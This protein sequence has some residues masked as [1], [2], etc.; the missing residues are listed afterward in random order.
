MLKNI[1][2]FF[3]FLLFLL[4]FGETNEQYNQFLSFD[5]MYPNSL[6][7]NDG[8]ILLIT[9]QGIYL[10]EEANDNLKTIMNFTSNFTLDLTNSSKITLMQLPEEDGGEIFCLVKK[11]IFVFSYNI[12]LLKIFDF[13]EEEA[14]VYYSLSFFSKTQ[15]DI[16]IYYSCGYVDIS[17]NFILSF[18]NMKI[19]ESVN[20]KVHNK[21]FNPINSKGELV[22]EFH[23]T[24]SCEVME[25]KEKG[26]LLVCFHENRNAKEIGISIFDPMV[27]LEPI[28]ELSK[29]YVNITNQI[30][31]IRTSVL[32]NKK[33][34]LVCFLNDDGNGAYCF[35]YNIDSNSYSNPIQYSNYCNKRSLYFRTYYFKQIDEF[36]FCCGKYNH[37]FKFIFF[38][39]Y[40]EEFKELENNY[41]S[42]ELSHY[43][44]ICIAYLINKSQYS[45][46]L[47]TKGND[48][49]TKTRF[50]YIDN[51]LFNLSNTS[52]VSSSILECNKYLNY[53]KNKCIDS[54]PDG[55]YLFD[56][57]K[58]IIEKCHISCKLC[59]IGPNEFSNNCKQCI[60]NNYYLE[61]GNCNFFCSENDPLF[62]VETKECVKFCSVD[63]I[64]DKK[65]IISKVTDKS[66]ENINGNIRHIILNLTMNKTI[67]IIIEGNNIIYQISTTDNIKNNNYN[68][69]S[70]DFGSCERKI[71]EKYGIDYIIIQKADIIYNNMTIVKYELYNTNNVSENIDLS[72][73]KDDKIQIYTPLKI[74]DEYIENYYKL[75]REGYDILNPND[76]FYND[77]CSPFTSDYETDMILYDRKITY[78]DNNLTY[79]ETGCNFKNVN[80]YLMKVQC[81]CEVKIKKNNKISNISFDDFDLIDSFYKI[82]KFSNFK[83]IFCFNLV[84][85]K[86][87]QSRN[88]G[89]YFLIII[90]ILFCICLIMYFPNDKTY[91]A[92][93]IKKILGSMNSDN[94]NLILFQKS[95]PIKKNKTQK[96]SQN[97]EIVNRNNKSKYH[98][99][100]NENKK[101][102][103]IDS[104]FSV[105]KKI[106]ILKDSKT[107]SHE[108]DYEKKIKKKESKEIKNSKNDINSNSDNYKYND[109]ELNSMDYKDAI[110]F[111][112]RDYL[113]YYLSLLKKKQLILFTFIP[114]DDYNIRIVKYSLF[115]ISV[116]LYFTV[117]AFFFVDDSLH[118]IYQAQGIF[119]FL[120][121]LPQI[122]YSSLI[123]F[124]GNTII[125]ALA[126]SEKNLLNIKKYKNRMKRHNEC[127]KLYLSIRKKLF[128][129]FIVGFIFLI[130]FWYFIS[131]FCAV[132]KNTQ[133]IYLKDCTISF[134]LSMIY[135]FVL[136]LFPGIFRIH[137]LKKEERN[138]FYSIGNIIALL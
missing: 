66:L 20:N 101:E 128:I 35:F 9:N 120:I 58:G 116:S 124:L 61:G 50:F 41:Y 88:Y 81:E 78:Y 94:F 121:Q 43:Q 11:Q 22:S 68:I 13:I 69:S 112:K 7:L 17:K 6:T 93:L 122:L 65:C 75:L 113:Q 14:N 92:N 80:I 137:S 19:K 33:R 111:D 100:S 23:S 64:L 107:K 63:E 131:A 3:L 117:N 97:D 132:Y 126:L 8:N 83:V 135:P 45:F 89:S 70:I 136:N 21:V 47:D 4:K 27:K 60:N 106:F 28:E 32:K 39:S 42:I 44:S 31:F 55:F 10:Y 16:S 103:N 56:K 15:N 86:K 26:K 104:T 109:E 99:S 53:E 57:S 71:K 12:T 5:S 85:S 105:S 74:S 2:N 91:I 79:C 24:I 123:T 108:H 49:T 18:Y 73:C 82:N 40:N 51:D 127:L 36:V 34:T 95:N 30:A 102:E 118:E 134:C 130:F 98:F 138:C 25:N 114:N 125:K 54:I 46:I 37:V 52:S 87:G 48:T 90:T 29:V 1:K 77:V 84:F 129:F 72:I 59:D 76:T 115:L 96:D 67:N 38:N 62:K 133:I 119:N 110:K